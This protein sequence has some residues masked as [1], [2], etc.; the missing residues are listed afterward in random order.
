[1]EWVILIF[2]FL[3]AVAVGTAAYFILTIG[4]DCCAL[5]CLQIP[6]VNIGCEQAQV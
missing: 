3:C 5:A 6:A 4:Y 1:M 2:L